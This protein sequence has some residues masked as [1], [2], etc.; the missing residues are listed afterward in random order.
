[1]RV[2]CFVPLCSMTDSEAEV[3]EVNFETSYEGEYLDGKRHGYGKAVSSTGK[4]MYIYQGQWKNDMTDGF[5]T[6]E[7]A[8]EKYVG[9]WKEGEMHGKATL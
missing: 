8:E 5:G 4:M 7:T 1:M 3:A 9:G 2:M 6:W